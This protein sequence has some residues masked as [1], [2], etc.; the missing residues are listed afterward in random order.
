IYKRLPARIYSYIRCRQ[1]NTSADE[2]VTFD[3]TILDPDGIPLIDI[4]EFSVRRIENPSRVSEGQARDFQSTPPVHWSVA[5]AN[6]TL[7]SAEGAEAFGR[8]L[9]AAAA[10]EIVVCPQDLKILMRPTEVR[11]APLGH[12]EPSD[13]TSG[14]AV[15]SQLV[16]IWE[17]LLGVK[18]VRLQDNFFELGGHSLLAAR[19]SARVKKIWGRSVPLG[20][21]FQAPTIEKMATLLRG[22]DAANAPKWS[23][24]VAAI[25]SEGNLPPFLCVDAGPYF[26]LLAERLRPDQPFLGLRLVDTENLP[27]H[28]TMADIA[29]YHIKTIREIQP[30]GPY[31]LGGWSASGLVA[32]EI[33]QQLHDQGHEVALL[34]LFDVLN[35][36]ALRP[37]SR[38]DLLPRTFVFLKWKFNYHFIQLRRLNRHDPWTY[39]SNLLRR[40]RLDL[41][42]MLWVIADMIQRRANRRIAVA[43][44]EPSKA[45]FVAAREYRPR[46]Y[47]GHVLLFRSAIQSVGPYHDAKQGWGHL[48][49]DAL[50]ICQMP[51]DHGDMF[52]EPH[53]QLLAKELDRALL[54]ARERATPALL[55]QHR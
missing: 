7:S 21:L 39:I 30:Q 28:F 3:I 15:E 32:Y 55:G 46:P 10:G 47:P 9:S 19:L 38:W 43:P 4:E 22:T 18:P 33:A 16:R 52:R 41:S 53:V 24:R 37:S 1:A 2:V 49:G 13:A 26:R 50:E 27:I 11:S 42:R 29:A 54:G 40:I 51:G 8:I 12:S 23:P 34:V 25:R 45:V 36:T 17:D 14:D 48:V 35:S 31:Y 6:Q 20:T 44:R 5:A